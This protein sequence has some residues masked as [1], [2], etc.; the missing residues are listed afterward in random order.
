MGVLLMERRLAQLSQALEDAQALQEQSAQQ[1]ADAHAAHKQRL[2]NM[3]V[4][5]AEQ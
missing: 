3:Q 2:S 4:G 1:L 5:S